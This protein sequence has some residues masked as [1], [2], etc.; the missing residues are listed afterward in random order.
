MKQKNDGE[1]IEM[2]ICCKGAYINIENVILICFYSS[3]F[4]QHQHIP[5]VLVNG[6]DYDSDQQ[7]GFYKEIQRCH[8]RS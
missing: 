3:N 1:S 5:L 4:K 2:R 7:S 8:V 6:D